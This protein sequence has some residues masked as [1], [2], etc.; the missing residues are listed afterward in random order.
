MIEKIADLLRVLRREAVIRDLHRY[1][2]LVLGV[3][4]FIVASRIVMNGKTLD[5]IWRALALCLIY[6]VV[7]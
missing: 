1:M 6:W 7:I 2:V 5:D 4:V 3:Y